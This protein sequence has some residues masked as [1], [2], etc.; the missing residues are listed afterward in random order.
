MANRNL[1]AAELESL[2]TPLI[3]E[4]RRRLEVLG[5]GD[6]DLQ[7]ALRRKLYKELSYDE[8]GKPMQRRK[9]KE[10]KRAEQNNTCPLCRTPLPEKYVVLDRLEA[11]GGYTPE[12]TRLLCSTCDTRVQQSRGYK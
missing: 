3:E 7:W 10:L 8:R 11:M 2:F 5:G 9:L 12:N 6:A 1:S 4:V